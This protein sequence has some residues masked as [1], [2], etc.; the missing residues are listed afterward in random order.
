M[1]TPACHTKACSV[2]LQFLLTHS[3]YPG[4]YAIQDAKIALVHSYYIGIATF[5]NTS[6]PE[7]QSVGQSCISTFIELYLFS[8]NISLPQGLIV[9]LTRHQL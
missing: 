1:R 4:F 2:N 5:S 9:Q 6:Q 8:D 7:I 3:L